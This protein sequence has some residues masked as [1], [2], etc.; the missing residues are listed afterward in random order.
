MAESIQVTLG[1]S[2]LR[3]KPD[4]L[5]WNEVS[6]YLRQ[7]Y[8]LSPDE[9]RR[10][11]KSAE[12]QRLFQSGGDSSMESMLDSVLKDPDVIGKRAEW[13]EFAKFN[14]V[15]RRII[16]ELSTVY[17]MPAK[18]TVTDL[19]SN[20]RYQEVQRLCRMHEVMQR[21]NRL[22][23]LHRAVVVMP[24]MRMSSA[25]ELLPVLDVITPAKFSAVR[26][27]MDP[28]LCIGIIVE[29]DFAIS[30]IGQSPPKWTLWTA[31]E[32]IMFDVNGQALEETHRP[33]AFGAIPAL[34]FTLEP[35]DGKLIDCETGDDLV[36]AHKSIWFLNV[37]HMKE[38]KSATKQPVLQ[39][40]LSRV[41]R[42]QADDSE[43]PLIL[44]DGT[45]ATTLDRAMDL[46]MFTASARHVYET[47][48]AN[49]GLASSLLHHQGV[50]SAD[51]RELL[52]VPL[53]ELRLQQQIPFRDFERDLAIIMSKVVADKRPDLAFN[54][55][56]WT[57]DFADPQT[58]LGTHEA[59]VVLEKDLQMGFTS[60]VAEMIRRNPDLSPEQAESVLK[61]FQDDRTK[62]LEWMRDFMALSGGMPQGALPKEQQDPPTDEETA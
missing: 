42:N 60:E 1:W 6:R 24:R 46:S 17:A 12:R 20:A 22:A 15:L 55:D 13:I 26:H 21:V 62:R 54:L 37:V 32:S 44:P 40:D 50:Q 36:A 39:G 18:R 10:K 38:A 61:R 11:E 23:N 51:A 48:A 4:P 43:V 19:E 25:G 34:L 52:R 5:P 28:S 58:P 7:H 30:R 9:M 47:A 3:D 33:H 45:T 27:P 41:A 8:L 16:S 29:N 59:Q 14:N 53:R 31:A 57:I 2:P 35:P 49:Y 56:G